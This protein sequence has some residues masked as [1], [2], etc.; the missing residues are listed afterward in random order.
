[1][2]SLRIKSVALSKFAAIGALAAMVCGCSGQAD[3]G[4]EVTGEVAQATGSGCTGTP[5]THG[6]Q[7]IEVDGTGLHV[8]TV[9]D[10]YGPNPEN[11]P[12]GTE[13]CGQHHVWDQHGHSYY[14]ARV[15]IPW[16]GESKHVFTIDKDFPND[17]L[18]CAEF[19]SDP[20]PACLTV[21]K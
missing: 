18:V 3:N 20:G 12:Q 6:T 2:K 11:V 17:D 15:C 13:V 7:C 1:M 14:S 10:T 21:H 19:T 9:K 4:N 8:T 16:A 5:K